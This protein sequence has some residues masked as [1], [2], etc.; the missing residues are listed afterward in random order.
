MPDRREWFRSQRSPA[1]QPLELPSCEYRPM[2][3]IGCDGDDPCCIVCDGQGYELIKVAP[4]TMED[5]E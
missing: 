5:I 4:M 2:P 1:R 3:C